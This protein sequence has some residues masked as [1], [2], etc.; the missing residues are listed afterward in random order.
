MTL[1]LEGQ[2]AWVMCADPENPIESDHM[3]FRLTYEGLLLSDS[4]S[5][6]RTE[7]KHKIRRDFHGRLKK[8]WQIH[9]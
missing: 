3:E 2:R 8:Y 6:S 1:H 4:A 5:G 9:P 7:R